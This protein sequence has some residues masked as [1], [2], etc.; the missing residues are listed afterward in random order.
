MGSKQALA[1]RRFW[2]ATPPPHRCH[3]HRVPGV[4]VRLAIAVRACTAGSGIMLRPLH[5]VRRRTMR[6]QPSS[7]GGGVS[8]FP[9]GGAA[10]RYGP[11]GVIPDSS[12]GLGS[13]PSKVRATSTMVASGEIAPAARAAMPGW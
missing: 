4:P 6:Q 5:G 12:G 2:P 3:A 8:L 13:A 11:P 9:L 1:R 7:A 10:A